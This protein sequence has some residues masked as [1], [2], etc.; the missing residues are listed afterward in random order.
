MRFLVVGLRLLLLLWDG[1][2]DLHEDGQAKHKPQTVGLIN[3]KIIITE[4]N[5]MYYNVKLHKN[6]R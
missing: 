2:G 3:V 6:H 1:V 4:W 5:N